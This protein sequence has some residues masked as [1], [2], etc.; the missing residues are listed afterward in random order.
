VTRVLPHHRSVPRRALLAAAPGAA[1]IS[2]HDKAAAA[3]RGDRAAYVP[4]RAQR[5]IGAPTTPGLAAWGLAYNP[6][7]DELA[8]GDYV[9][10]QVRRYGRDGSYRGD[11]TNP[12]GQ[13]PGVASALSVDARDGSYYL[14]VTG[15]TSA[16]TDVVKYAPDGSY[17]AGFGIDQ[18][19]AWLAVDPTTGD[20]WI[21]D[22]FGGR[23]VIRRYAVDLAAQRLTQ[24][25]TIDRPG[26]G[27]GQ[28]RWATGV[29]TDAAGRLYVVDTGNV[30]VHVFDAAGSWLRD[31]GDRTSL[32]GD[33]RGIAL[34]EDL[35]RVYVSNAAGA[36]VAAFALNSG[37]LVA[38]F[39][40]E[41]TGPGQFVD[42]ARQLAVTPDHRI[43]AADYGLRRVVSFDAD[44]VAGPVFPNPGLPEDPAGLAV[45]R[46]LAVDPVTGEVLVADGFGQS[47]TRYAADGSLVQRFGRRGSTPP[48]G[49][50]YPKAVAVDPLTRNVWVANHEGAPHLVGFTPDFGAVVRQIV[51]P[52][53][54]LDL[55]FFR[56]LL[57]TLQTTPGAVRVYN[58][59]TGALVR[60]WKSPI[61]ALTA[62]GID[63]ATGN[64]WVTTSKRRLGILTPAGRFRSIALGG[65][66]A[67][68]AF[69]GAEAYVSDSAGGRI[70]VL[71]RVTLAAKAVVGSG[72]GTGL[73]QL[74]GPSALDFDAAGRLYVVELRGGRVTAFGTEAAPEAGSAVVTV[75]GLGTAYQPMVTGTAS[76]A[77]GVAHVEVSVTDQASGRC[78]DA[79]K[80][81][82]VAGAVW[83]RA[84]VW[85]PVTAPS[86]RLTVQLPLGPDRVYAVTARVVDRAGR[87]VV[88]PAA[89]LRHTW[90]PA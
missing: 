71:D 90:A 56:G 10:R 47:I 30:T 15:S 89:T 44:G 52:R 67:G 33:L 58:P 32:A 64:I 14:A 73:G 45:P 7:S 41:G 21:P 68:V 79:A 60:Q 3:A 6:V 51:A 39:G 17:L 83:S 19:V 77:A 35:D 50:N 24:V 22:A 84:V 88:G 9:A 81:R 49:M 46:G 16:A 12:S 61:G 72:S 80:N 65:V 63:P 1:L 87:V 38:H 23:T 34:D 13:V 54:T 4:L 42:G 82:W 26:T 36:T 11:F 29:A 57:Y 53:F 20:L 70:R 62:L 43:W 27:P 5:I 37:S 28:V 59:T 66:G 40:G 55:K 75:T 25:A 31:L 74:S 2:P 8:V 86:W 78:F 85:G 69:R 76:A 48:E 18:L